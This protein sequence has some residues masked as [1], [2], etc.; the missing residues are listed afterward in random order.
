MSKT[1]NTV[2]SCTN[3]NWNNLE[4]TELASNDRIPSQELAYARYNE[5]QLY[6]QSPEMVLDNYGIPDGD[7][8][9]YQTVK[10][11]AH[12]KL[13]LD[14]NPNVENETEEERNSRKKKL[15]TF[16]QKLIELD[17]LM[18]SDEMK[19][20]LFGKSKK[21]YTYTKIVR[22]P[23]VQVDSDDSDEENDDKEEKVVRPDFMK[24]KIPLSYPDEE[25]IV[26]VYRKN[27]EDTEEFEA[28]GKYS[29]M[30]LK[31]LSELKSHIVYMR[32][33]KFVIHL[34]KIWASKQPLA[35]QSLKNYGVTFKL[36]RCEIQ[37]KPIKKQI[38]TDDKNPFIDSDDDDE[39]DEDN[40]NE[41]NNEEK[42][43]FVEKEESESDES[44]SE[45]KPVKVKKRNIKKN[46]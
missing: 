13:P 35:G 44:E 38:V 37:S 20:K 42:K 7:G 1:N 15:S 10:Q 27:K 41:K 33:H 40:D 14:I 34:S 4:I 45:E 25:V 31:T 11:Q 12:L 21:K 24:C 46:A 29:K 2:T 9:F 26:D 8:P 43:H 23:V 32:K 5:N 3:V 19:D 30:E 6:I 18:E 28:D 17:E 36:V 22:T 16:K 39:D